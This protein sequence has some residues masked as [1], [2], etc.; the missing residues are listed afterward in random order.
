MIPSKTAIRKELKRLL[1]SSVL[2][3]SERLGRFLQ[4]TVDHAINERKEVL[5]EFLI[6]TEVYDR[7]PPYHP[8]HDSIVRT[9]ARRLRSKLKEYYEAE[10]KDDP[11]LI[12]YRPGSYIPVFRSNRYDDR[13]KVLEIARPSHQVITVAVLPFQDGSGTEISAACALGITDE[14][15]HKMTH[16]PGFRVIAAIS[17][18][19]IGSQSTDLS[20]LVNQFGIEWTIDGTVRVSE[21]QIRV[22]ARI[23]SAEGIEVSSQRFQA[24]ARVEDLFDLQEKIASALASRISPQ[25]SNFAKYWASLKGTNPGHDIVAYYADLLSAEALLDH[26]ISSQVPAALEKFQSIAKRIPECARTQCGIAQCYLR[27]AQRGIPNSAKLVLEARTAAMKAVQLAP[28]MIGAHSAL[29]AVLAMELKW[30]EA[31]RTFRQA[32]A[33]GAHHGTYRQFGLF[34]TAMGRSDEGGEYLARA[35]EIDPFSYVQKVSMARYFYHSRRY[36]E[37]LLY[38]ST[39]CVYGPSPV[40]SSVFHAFIYAASGNNRAAHELA[41]SLQRSATLTPFL[42]STIAELYGLCGDMAGA[43]ALVDEYELFD[44]SVPL[45]NVRRAYLSLALEDPTSALCYLRKAHRDHEAELPWCN[46][47]PRF[48]KL[49][50]QSQFQEIFDRVLGD[51]GSACRLVSPRIFSLAPESLHSQ[52]Q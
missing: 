6:G 24:E 15:R 50:S 41:R 8:S 48:D 27:T 5:K 29:A 2:V 36:Q 26:G 10:G 30:D 39:P 52:H 40:E 45:S 12:Y 22:T 16:T 31:E 46:T 25:L 11:V 28:Q 43:Q 3:Q 19:Q 33:L 38:L 32:V 7:R 18:A 44:P 42:I 37:G 47:D 14:V 20:T 34:L 49:T 51:T 35:N 17:I 13:K 9:E 23:V 21:K 4:F 1:D